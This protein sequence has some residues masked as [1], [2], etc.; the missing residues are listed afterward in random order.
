ML[1]TCDN[2]GTSDYSQ[3]KKIQ[4]YLKVKVYFLKEKK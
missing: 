1:D 2:M 4:I 3:V